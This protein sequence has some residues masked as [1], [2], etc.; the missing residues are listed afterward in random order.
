MIWIFRRDE[1]LG[2]SNELNGEMNWRRTVLSLHHWI[3]W[4]Q[5]SQIIQILGGN[6]CEAI[7]WNPA[8][9]NHWFLPQLIVG[10]SGTQL[11]AY[12]FQSARILVDRSGSGE[13]TTVDLCWRNRL[14]VWEQTHQPAM[15]VP[16]CLMDLTA[17]NCKNWSLNL[18]NLELHF[19]VDKLRACV[20][21]WFKRIMKI[22][23]NGMHWKL[24]VS[25][26][27]KIW[28]SDDGFL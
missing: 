3:Y 5:C 18:C 20:N 11:F 17:C 7:N 21:N 22:V 2:I 8:S 13:I 19:T 26:C 27:Q 24:A 10:S 25:Y 12:L 9:S 14:A 4:L 1:K 23:V 15:V 6:A 16:W 28:L